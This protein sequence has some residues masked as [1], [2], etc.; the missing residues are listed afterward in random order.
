MEIDL[1]MML[2]H[3]LGRHYRFVGEGGTVESVNIEQH[4]C[5]LT[6]RKGA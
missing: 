3:I 5:I 1:G 2:G 6:R 4:K